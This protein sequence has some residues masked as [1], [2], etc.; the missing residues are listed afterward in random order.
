MEF[1]AR[2]GVSSGPR[3]RLWRSLSAFRVFEQRRQ[4]L[5][6]QHHG[7]AN[8]QSPALCF[9][10]HYESSNGDSEGRYHH[11]SAVIVTTNLPLKPLLIRHEGLFA[12]FDRLAALLGLGA[13]QFE[14]A[15]FNKEFHVTFARPSL[16]LRCAAAGHDGVP[17][18]L[19]K[20]CSGI[21]ALPDHCLSRHSFQPADFDSAIQ[22]IDGISP[23]AE[24]AGARTA[25]S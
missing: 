4:S 19:A 3:W 15:A 23:V 2:L 22:V 14:S 7:G 1:L 17:D 12:S 9:D 21:S 8:R 10:Y 18:E 11:F 25:R 6:R 13:I 16:G 20:V 24:F 5:R